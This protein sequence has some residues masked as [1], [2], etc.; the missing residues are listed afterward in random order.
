M[1]VL[2]AFLLSVSVASAGWFYSS[3][4][5]ATQALIVANGCIMIPATLQHYG[6][7]MINGVTYVD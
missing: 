3:K 7:V 6:V 2:F 5:A 1:R 4:T